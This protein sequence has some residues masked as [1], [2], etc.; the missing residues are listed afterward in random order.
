[1][2]NA[3]GDV[4]VIGQRP[5]QKPWRIGVQDPRNSDKIIA[6][7]SLT[8]WDTMETSGDYQRYFIKDQVR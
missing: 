3:G 8:D 1:M 7:L 4:R 2:V 5:D 6:K